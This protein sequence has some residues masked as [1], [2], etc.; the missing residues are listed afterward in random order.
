MLLETVR[1]VLRGERAGDLAVWLEH[2][3]TPQ[4]LARLGGVQG[5]EQVARAFAM[6][7]AP[8]DAPIAFRFIERRTDGALLGKAGLA[9]IATPAAPEELRGAVQIGWT[10]RA[11]AWGQGYAREVS[12]SL[13]DHAFGAL[14]LEQLY[15][16]TSEANA[17]SWGLM[18]R[19]GMRRR[20]DLDYVDPDYPPEDNPTVV[21]AID[22]AAFS[23]QRA[24]A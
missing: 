19:L 6:M 12:E 10:L 18:Q 21:W 24:A 22:R 15:A 2:M 1:L 3:N 4:V 20:A 23:A 5:E 16:Q 13:L 11:D 17:A 9:P 14:G 8:D 7:A